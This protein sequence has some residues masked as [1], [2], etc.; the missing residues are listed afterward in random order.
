MVTKIKGGLYWRGTGR[1]IKTPCRYYPCR[2]PLLTAG[3][4]YVRPL[5]SEQIIHRRPPTATGVLS[6][7]RISP[8]IKLS[9]AVGALP[10]TS[11]RQNIEIGFDLGIGILR[12]WYEQVKCF[13]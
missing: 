9:G 13:V 3:H 8:K 2:I 11:D 4:P 10:F 5:S 1:I 6:A 7:F 12:R